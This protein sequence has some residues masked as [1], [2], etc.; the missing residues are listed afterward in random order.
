MNKCFL[1]VG[2]NHYEMC[3]SELY[4]CGFAHFFY[5]SLFIVSYTSTLYKFGTL[6]D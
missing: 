1:S 3:E 4:L 5:P 2:K 6:F